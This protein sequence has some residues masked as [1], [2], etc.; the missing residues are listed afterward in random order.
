MKSD[1][2]QLLFNAFSMNCVGHI[3]QGL[4]THP[5]DKSTDY[6]NLD[7]WVSLVQVLEKGLF[8][9]LFLADVLGVKDVYRQ[10]VDISMR[11]GIQFP[12][13]DPIPMIGA[14][15][16]ATTN[17]GFGVT[18]NLTYE[19]PYLLARRLSTLDHITQGRIGWNIVTGYLDSAARA[20]GMTEQI[21]HDAR[22]DRG[23]EF[24]E[25][26][27]K[28]WEGS[29]DDDAIE[30]DRQGRVYARPEKV[31]RV[32][33][34]GRFFNLDAYHLCSPSPQRTPLLFQAGASERGKLFAASHAECVFVSGQSKDSVRMIASSIRDEAKRIGRSP[35]DVKIIMGVS[36]IVGNTD[37]QANEKY[38]E[39]IEYASPE[40]GLANFAAGTGI[41]F[42]KYELDE[43]ILPPKK[44]NGIQSSVTATTQGKNPKT[45]RQ[46]L[47]DFA[48]GGRYT[49]IIGSPQTVADE[50]ISWARET[51]IDG[52]NLART[53]TPDCF[54]DVV[55]LLIPELQNRGVYKTEYK[56]GTFR[57]KIFGNGD[58]LPGRHP[59]AK[60]R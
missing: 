52:F 15:A 13:N 18:L 55:N 45:R 32:R 6:N 17:I 23:D 51:G 35:D 11:E 10:S 49:P 50:M 26:T 39:Y 37:A 16:A 59:A 21:E 56:S 5:R 28:L 8:D 48:L 4:W 14:L 53:V 20:M 43:P 27:Y 54:E 47:A 36:V 58:R 30:M 46:L 25:L 2:P 3:N 24:L 34:N 9:G 22:Y 42:S 12:I 40:A 33:H 7:H 31:R 57:E 38:A 19:Q 1:I 41:D 60:W 44:N 29:W